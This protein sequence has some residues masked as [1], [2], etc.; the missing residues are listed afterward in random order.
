MPS[1]AAPSD[2]MVQSGI[3]KKYPKKFARFVFFF[4]FVA[5][6]QI[7]P[8]FSGGIKTQNTRRR[9]RR[10]SRRLPLRKAGG[11]QCFGH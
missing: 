8:V 9:W 1:L 2:I 4:S 11:N 7:E 6:K 3:E 5:S 10:P